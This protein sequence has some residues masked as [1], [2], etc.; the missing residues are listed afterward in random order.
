MST[1]L[2]N[3]HADDIVH[4]MAEQ[5]GDDSFTDLFHKEASLEKIAPMIITSQALS[6]FTSELEG[7][8]NAAQVWNIWKKHLPALQKEENKL[9]G[10]ITKA[11]EARQKKLAEFGP[12]QTMPP[13]AADD[14][15]VPEEEKEADDR[16]VV[17]AKFVLK[18]L[19]K[20]ADALDGQGF[21]K[22]A[23]IVD[24]TIEKISKKK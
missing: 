8:A 21:N 13:A 11:T 14:C 2:K 12:G 15:A 6:A 16:E 4:A 19:V 3:K 18:H 9:P 22:M 5:L 24:E 7:A 1:S 10:T 20:I 23:N 17:A